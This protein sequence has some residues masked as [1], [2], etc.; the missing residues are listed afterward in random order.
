MD[1]VRDP[2]RHGELNRWGYTLTPP[3]AALGVFAADAVR[4]LNLGDD[5]ITDYL[6]LSFSQTDDIGHDF[7]PLEPGTVGKPPPS[8]PSSREAD[9]GPG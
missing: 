6:A 5:A 7:G 3:D 2:S 9:A 4:V 1:E 8:G